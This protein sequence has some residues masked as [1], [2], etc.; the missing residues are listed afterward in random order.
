MSR[1][2]IE[3]TPVTASLHLPI[4]EERE[5]EI[6]KAKSNG[7]SRNI[8]KDFQQ[9]GTG[10][11]LQQPVMGVQERASSFNTQQHRTSTTSTGSSADMVAQAVT[12]KKRLSEM[13]NDESEVGRNLSHG[14]TAGSAILAKLRNERCA[15]KERTEG[16]KDGNEGDK[17]MVVFEEKKETSMTEKKRSEGEKE[18][19]K[20]EPKGE[21]MNK[22]EKEKE[23]KMEITRQNSASRSRRR[24]KTVEKPVKSL[25]IASE[26]ERVTPSSDDHT[27]QLPMV[28]CTHTHTRHTTHLEYFKDC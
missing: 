11:N 28:Q 3:T 10:N 15:G 5:D 14:E 8:F 4:R 18:S 12:A 19:D 25:G 6:T 21:G 22:G 16:E 17:E 24:N 20:E 1:K 13:E 23:E 2:V 27:M 26:S 9:Q 7:E